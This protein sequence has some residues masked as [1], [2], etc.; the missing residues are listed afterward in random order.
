MLRALGSSPAAAA[1][2]LRNRA[3]G[4]GT[5][6]AEEADD[7][8]RRLVL[9]LDDESA[10]GQDVLYGARVDTGEEENPPQPPFPKGGSEEEK[11][12]A[13]T[14][15]EARERRRLN[16]LAR[17]VEKLVGKSD[18]KLN[19]VTGLV[20]KLVADGYN[21][22]VFCRFIPTVD[23]VADHLRKKLKSATV[24]A[25][26]GLLPAEERERR[27][28]A[29]DT[30]R[31]RV[32]VCTDCLSEGIN[33]QDALD[34]VVHYDLSWNPTRHEQREGRVDRYGQ[35][36]G[37]VR[38]VT[39]YGANNPIDGI[40]LRVLLRKHDEIRKKLGISVP[41]PMETES[42][43]EAIFESLLLREDAGFHPEQAAFDFMKRHDQQLD[44]E[45]ASAAER[46]EKSR[47]LFAQH[48]I[49]V[50]EVERE[51]RAV[52]GA[53]GDAATVEA[54]L[55]DALPPLGATVTDCPP[56]GSKGGRHSHD[57]QERDHLEIDLSE[58]SRDLRALVTDTVSKKEVKKNDVRLRA[59]FQHPAPP[60][61]E[62]LTR[63]HPLVATVAER[64][65]ASALDPRGQGLARRC[66]TIRSADVAKRTTFLLLRVRYHIVTRDR[67]GEERP[68]LAEDLLTAA[69]EGSP[70]RA[71]WLDGDD[72]DKLFDATPAANVDPE[73][74]RTQLH[75]I[76][77]RFDDVRPRLDEIAREH[78]EKLL[79]AHRRVR[80]VTKEGLHSLRVQH[81]EPTDV[82]GLFVYLP[83]PKGGGAA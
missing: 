17:D 52:Q 76:V 41:V 60:G 1:R 28:E 35:P 48:T 67:D 47:N 42:V 2:S 43:Q 72:V 7:L 40:V 26:S 68:L 37:V 19:D 83:V 61:G 6:T 69:F 53:L 13:G 62:V 5:E 15:T 45:W 25:I 56:R 36:K 71:R 82:L 8:G 58:T 66:G 3:Q 54:F 74:A 79:Q 12:E 23:Y 64:T 81:L 18:A 44:V 50:D 65:W 73:L 31:P 51:L 30:E 29:L 20:K 75:R 14:S 32:L 57:H 63:T 33:L 78:G 77:D 10:E 27:I 16:D 34:A 21:P 38:T 59:V 11:E 49:K 55:R 22:I 9:D 70:E 24:E 4:L 39:F 46:E 80:Q